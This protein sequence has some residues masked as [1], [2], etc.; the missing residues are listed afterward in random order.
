ML[1]H[2]MIWNL[3]LWLLQG[4]GGAPADLVAAIPAEDYFRSRAMD[5]SLPGL[6]E[7]STR[8]AMD[9][10]A[11]VRQL[12]ALHFLARQ[13]DQ[14]KKEKNAA[15]LIAAIEDVAA[16]RAGQDELGF[17]KDYA[18]RVLAAL[19]GTKLATARPA[20]SFV[21]A[22]RLIPANATLLHV[23]DLRTGA[24]TD[25]TAAWQD[26]LLT[27][28]KAR[29][30]AYD[31]A[32]RVGNIRVERIAFA[33]FEEAHAGL[34]RISGR[35]DCKRI[36]DAFQASR[37]FD[38][39]PRQLPA[40]NREPV[41]LLESHAF[42]VALIG[43]RELLFAVSR[44]RNVEASSLLLKV[45]ECGTGKAKSVNDGPWQQ[46]IREVAPDASSLGIV[47]AGDFLDHVRFTPFALL[48]C[49][50]FDK[51][52][53]VSG[54]V[55]VTGVAKP[56]G[57]AYRVVGTFEQATDARAFGDWFARARDLGVAALKKWAVSFR[58]AC[59]NPFC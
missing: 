7:L 36:A 46:T 29:E 48:T 55:A 44:D 6:V 14:L 57:V 8:P 24:K 58:P 27:Y 18:A 13:A 3:F 39:K 10:G 31:L 52:P 34:I 47:R 49:A 16:A 45:L 40:I 54:H 56:A 11:S 9:P 51:P 32:E 41:T 28:T 35:A 38:G 53:A 43:N 50:A 20:D 37:L 2:P 23:C 33:E 4:P 21:D 26:F 17:A 5:A 15:A 12:V 30:T 25:R 1:A 59:L 22:C 42:S 19:A